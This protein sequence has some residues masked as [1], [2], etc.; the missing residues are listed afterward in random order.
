M[1]K[2]E[3][4]R[5]IDKYISEERGWF[6][7]PVLA[8]QVILGSQV[9]PRVGFPAQRGACFPFSLCSLLLRL[10]YRSEVNK[11]FRK[12]LGGSSCSV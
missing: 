3:V 10:L 2:S 5:L 11:I 6:C 1:L 12:S 4:N 9:E 7:F 8:A